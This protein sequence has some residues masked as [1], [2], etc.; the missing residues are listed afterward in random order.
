M[1]AWL[2][3][4]AMAA[5]IECALTIGS[6]DR[7]VMA[8]LSNKAVVREWRQWAHH[9]RSATIPEE[10]RLRGPNTD[11]DLST[12]SVLNWMLMYS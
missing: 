3:A 9:G 6:S 12:V 11:P 1:H 2:S 5:P 4:L 8:S 7:E 10:G